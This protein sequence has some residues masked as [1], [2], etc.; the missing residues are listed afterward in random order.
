MRNGTH[1][2]QPHPLTPHPPR[3]PPDVGSSFL[4][5]QYKTTLDLL[6]FRDYDST[7]HSPSKDHKM[8]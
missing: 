4:L 7:K 1:N 3:P 6:V 8:L 2:T 5:T